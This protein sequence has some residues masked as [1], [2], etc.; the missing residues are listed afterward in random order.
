MNRTSKAGQVRALSKVAV[1]LGLF[2][3][4]L[5]VFAQNSS[6]VL[7]AGQSQ[8][9]AKKAKRVVVISLDGLDARYLQRRDEFHLKIPTLRRL[10]SEGVSARGVLTVYPSVT[11]PAHTSLVTGAY[12]AR[13]GIFG[14]ERFEPPGTPQTGDWNW[15]ARYI[16][17][18]T[19]WDAAGR[20]GL[21]TAMISWPVSA[22]AGDYNLPEI[23]KSGISLQEALARII[24][25][26]RPQGLFQEI[27]RYDPALYQN[28]N[29]DEQD[30][31]RTRVAEYIITQKKPDVTLIHLF[32]LDHFQHKYG[33]FTS[34]AF[35]MLEKED[36]YV[37]RILSAAGTLDETAVFI[38]SDHGFLPISKLIHPN[39]LLAEAGLLK[40][41]GERDQQGHPIVTNVRAIA[42]VTSGS[43]SII[44][45]DPADRD[46]LKRAREVFLRFA[47]QNSNALSLVE[48]A[49][50]REF[51]GNTEAAF[52]LDAGDGYSFGNDFT[53]AVVTPSQQLGQHGY[54]PTRYRTSFIA[55]GAGLPGHQELGDIR[56]IDIGPT[57]AATLGLT[58]RDADGRALRLR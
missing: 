37:A 32:D 23:F 9:P 4:L 49:R 48:G 46:A 21:K 39:V 33:P 26:T 22:G 28:A 20:A 53:G 42:Y 13:H 51:G 40:V 30:D 16:H 47:R 57:I 24:A 17:A 18:D 58:L 1:L 6:G 14:N 8:N 5:L 11:Y 44:M 2:L 43:C 15:F 7:H 52:M 27:T 19:L 25:N 45:R 55:A 41:T 35:A 31:L 54:F 3:S 34:E 29:A 36:G 12:P 38:V 56:L 50:M 10:M